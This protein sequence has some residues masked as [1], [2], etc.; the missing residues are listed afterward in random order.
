M[1]KKAAQR[2][3]SLLAILTVTFLHCLSQNGGDAKCHA[4]MNG[5]TIPIF[6]S[7]SSLKKKL[8][9]YEDLNS[10]DSSVRSYVYEAGIF[11]KEHYKFTSQ[12]V[13]IVNKGKTDK[14][15]RQSFFYI[16][17]KS[18]KAGGI[19]NSS[20][21]TIVK[22]IGLQL[23]FLPHELK[24]GLG[25]ERR[26]STS[27]GNCIIKIYNAKRISASVDELEI[28]IELTKN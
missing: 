19:N 6:G 23:P 22:N 18:I 15:V 13:F 8:L 4:S 17:N 24:I 27:C 9:L 25:E 26:F 21:S 2:R 1:S 20:L 10:I 16:I 7:Y 28:N 5:H 12:V 3:F 11:E 14:I